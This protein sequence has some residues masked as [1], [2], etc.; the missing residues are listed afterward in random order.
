[1][2]RRRVPPLRY[3]MNVG[4]GHE[5]RGWSTSCPKCAG[6]R[7]TGESLREFRQRVIDPDRNA[8]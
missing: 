3:C 5:W 7:S 2:R 6:T 4:C 8:P 1:M